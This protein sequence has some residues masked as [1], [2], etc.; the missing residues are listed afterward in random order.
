MKGAGASHHR[1]QRITVRGQALIWTT[2]L[3]SLVAADL[4]LLHV[5]NSETMSGGGGGTKVDERCSLMPVTVSTL[6]STDE[7]IQ[8][9]TGRQAS[10]RLY[11][12]QQNT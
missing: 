11:F 7:L 6:G 4:S 5:G 12:S 3:L 9:S 10:T 8:E 1:D 2:V